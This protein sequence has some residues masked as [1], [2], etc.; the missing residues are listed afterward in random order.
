MPR[1]KKALLQSRRAEWSARLEQI[2][3]E[4]AKLPKPNLGDLSTL[5]AQRVHA[6]EERMRLRRRLLRIERLGNL[7]KAKVDTLAARMVDLGREHE[8]VTARVAELGDIHLKG[9]AA[10]I[11]AI[12]GQHTARAAL[13]AEAERTARLLEEA[14]RRLAALES[15]QLE[16]AGP[17]D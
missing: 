5:A 6:E 10:Q 2:Q 1:S 17:Q 13:E 11:G 3:G 7:I 15:G 8:R 12:V 4:L 9:K 16:V 14:E